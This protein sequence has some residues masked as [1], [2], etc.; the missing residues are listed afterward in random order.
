MDFLSNLIKDGCEVWKN[1]GKHSLETKSGCKQQ[2][3]SF[4]FLID[5]PESLTFLVECIVDV[6]Q[7][8]GDI[9]KFYVRQDERTS[10]LPEAEV[11]QR[12][13]PS[14]T[15]VIIIFIFNKVFYCHE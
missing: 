13:S 11:T 1:I 10:I 6:R 4:T 2:N 15:T 7:F 14:H 9:P 12:L 5:I 3:E 8:V